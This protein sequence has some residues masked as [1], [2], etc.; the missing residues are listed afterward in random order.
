MA[1]Y[2][3]SNSGL[4]TRREYTSFLAGNSQFIPSYALAAYDSI[5]TA[6]GTGASGVITFS[7]IP[8]TY[9]H[10]QLRILM[11]AASGSSQC[12]LRYNADTGSN[13]AYHQLY[14]SGSSAAAYSGAS[15]T[16]FS[17]GAVESST[18]PWTV[19]V[20]DIL[21]YANTNKYKTTRTLFGYD[22]NG[23][24]ELGLYSGLWMSSTAISSLTLTMGVNFTTTTSAA[25]YGIKGGN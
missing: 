16:T 22:S 8:S 9:T 4:L 11:K 7:S 13:Y 1:V 5:A 18:N 19:S 3:T 14:G 21:D 23:G 15:Q 12:N 25:L 17:V 2:K 6:T 24:G 10:L 20:I